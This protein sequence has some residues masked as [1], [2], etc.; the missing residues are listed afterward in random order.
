MQIIEADQYLH[1][2]LN[3]YRELIIMADEGEVSCDT[4]DCQGCRVF[5]GVIRE[6]AYKIR[7]LAEAEIANHKRQ[8]ELSEQT[9]IKGM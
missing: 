8:A 3:I 5:C 7:G 4:H 2:A 6:S 9:P 1:E